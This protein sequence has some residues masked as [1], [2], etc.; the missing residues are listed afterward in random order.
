MASWMAVF[1]KSEE[2]PISATSTAEDIYESPIDSDDGED[3]LRH[4]RFTPDTADNS[5][6]HDTDAHS[7]GVESN[8]NSFCASE[9]PYS[10]D[11]EE[12][13]LEHEDGFNLD[14]FEVD[15]SSDVHVNRVS[16][17]GFDSDE[18]SIPGEIHNGLHNTP[19]VSRTPR[20]WNAFFDIQ[21]DADEFIRKFPANGNSITK[22]RGQFAEV[23]D[24]SGVI[25]ECELLFHM[26]ESLEKRHGPLS[27]DQSELLRE[28]VRRRY[29]EIDLGIH[30][31]RVGQDEWVH[32]T[33]LRLTSPS[34]VASKHLNKHVRAALVKDDALLTRLQGAYEGLVQSSDEESRLDSCERAFREAGV[35]EPLEEDLQHYGA[36]SYFEFVSLSLGAT[37]APVQLAMYDTSDGLAKWIPSMLLGGHKFDGIWHT[38]VRV[39]GKEFWYG[40]GAFCHDPEG[41]PFGRPVR[42]INLGKTL[43]TFGELKEF[44]HFDLLYTFNRASYDV[45][46]HNCNDFSNEV[47]QFL[48][49]GQQIP[50]EVLMQPEWAKNASLT[51][52][53]KPILQERLGSFG[54]DSRCALTRQC[55]DVTEE[56]RRRLRKG[57]MALFRSSFI[58]RPYTVKIESDLMSEGEDCLYPDDARLAD[59]SC[60][61]PSTAQKP[62]NRA[63]WAEWKLVNRSGVP[64]SHL[65][66]CFSDTQACIMHLQLGAHLEEG[67]GVVLRRYLHQAF[68]PVCP[69]GHPL[70]P[71]SAKFFAQAACSICQIQSG[72]F[73]SGESRGS[74]CKACSFEVCSSCLQKGNIF[75]GGG[76][77]ADILTPFL[78]SDLLANPGWLKYKSRFYFFKA[79]RNACGAVAAEEVTKLV[80][81]L[82]LELGLPTLCVT[83]SQVEIDLCR[84][85]CVQ[86]SLDIAGE[87]LLRHNKETVE[88]QMFQQLFSQTL[89][90]AMAA[91]ND[92]VPFNSEQGEGGST[93]IRT[94]LR[95][96]GD[97]CVVAL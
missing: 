13:F 68:R 47:V 24:G 7:Q 51:K 76:V 80:N 32:F 43:R 45:L 75:R 30:E 1:G 34:H 65:Y 40:G 31:E 88:L 9:W 22:L 54:D 94:I 25:T 82:R 21:R 38:G 35:C 27:I 79:E 14:E 87:N 41:V 57:D 19:P 69:K 85:L 63:A 90:E 49:H 5:A 56:W 28:T 26:Q 93:R 15:D 52:V 18:E 97:G 39:F 23:D 64:V 96:M 46:N 33:M 29:A 83:D 61:M 12:G 84:L 11:N 50:E 89:M 37:L 4:R 53:L 62:S 91:G 6:Q 67:V 66:P 81:R 72:S 17:A 70:Q 92:A 48:L 20:A 71:R 16:R 36:L 78:A 60:F 55:D 42:I 77:F 44:L 3:R 73:M 74:C 8:T 59:I 95:N 10:E 2:E 58:E 86:H